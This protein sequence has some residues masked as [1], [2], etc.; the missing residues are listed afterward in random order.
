MSLAYSHIF[1]NIFEN[2]KKSTH[3][4]THATKNHCLPTT[5]ALLSWIHTPNNL[6]ANL[7]PTFFMKPMPGIDEPSARRQGCASPGL[8]RRMPPFDSPHKKSAGPSAT[9]RVT[10]HR[11]EGEQPRRVRYRGFRV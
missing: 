3:T 2:H 6:G 11:Q 5:V 8:M 9:T 7:T 4:Q 1:K 10:Y